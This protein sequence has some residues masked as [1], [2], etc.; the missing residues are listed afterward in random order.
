MLPSPRHPN[1]VVCVQCERSRPRTKFRAVTKK[2]RCTDCRRTMRERFRAARLVQR[3]LDTRGISVTVR[4][5]CRDVRLSKRPKEKWLVKHCEPLAAAGI[6]L[7]NDSNHVPI[8]PADPTAAIR[9]AYRALIP[10]AIVPKKGNKKET[11]AIPSGRLGPLGRDRLWLMGHLHRLARQP[12]V[13]KFLAKQASDV[14]DLALLHEGGVAADD[15]CVAILD[16]YR[17][18]CYKLA[19]AKWTSG[20][21]D[22]E[23]AEARLDE[24]ILIG[25]K[26]WTPLHP[27]KAACGTLVFYAAIR[28]LQ[29][30][31]RADRA[32]GVY[33]LPDNQGWS[34]A[35]VSY[36]QIMTRSVDDACKFDPGE[37]AKVGADGIG[38]GARHNGHA[39]TGIPVQY[40]DETLA[41][42]LAAAFSQLDPDDV[43]LITDRLVEKFSI[44]KIASARGITT[45]EATRRIRSAQAKLKDH[46]SDYEAN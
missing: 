22:K 17:R 31:T 11:E 19:L 32:E 27:R 46:L 6:V 37:D 8:L 7:V 10:L 14:I 3:D 44:K 26:R 42:D 16:R 12:G 36:D 13:S 21:M 40:S 45:G 15:A 23:S 38:G 39:A 28:E 29:I 35:A 1:H 43:K 24:G 33:E 25:A 2:P 4:D 34:Q 9:T 41:V 20:L 5:R 18:R 30:R